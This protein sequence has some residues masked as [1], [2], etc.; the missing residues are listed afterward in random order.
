MPGSE[1][2]YGLSAATAARTFGNAALP[3]SAG[4]WLPRHGHNCPARSQIASA[5]FPHTLAERP[6][7]TAASDVAGVALQAN[8]Y[9]LNNQ[10]GA[11]YFFIGLSP[12]LSC[13]GVPR[14]SSSKTSD[15]TDRLSP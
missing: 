2:L 7:A 15:R 9:G 10:Y 6:E 5:K 12:N 8:P 13:G 3:H 1:G 4:S 11:P 14:R